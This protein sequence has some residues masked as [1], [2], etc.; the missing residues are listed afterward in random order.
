MRLYK[1]CKYYCVVWCNVRRG[2]LKDDTRWQM[3]GAAAGL[4]SVRTMNTGTIKLRH[5]SSSSH[6]LR[7][8]GWCVWVWAEFCLIYLT[9]AV[10]TTPLC[11]GCGLWCLLSCT[12]HLKESLY[13][14]GK[15]D[16]VCVMD[17]YLLFIVKMNE[18]IVKMLRATLGA[19]AV[20]CCV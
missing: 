13:C 7:S 18:H 16:G 17:L 9:S 14:L 2:R 4:V 15:V 11:K 10:S 12:L 5:W 20:C 3:C 19:Q 6:R 1:L 8:P